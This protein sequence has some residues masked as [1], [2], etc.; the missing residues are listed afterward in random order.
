MFQKQ[1]TCRESWTGTRQLVHFSHK[2]DEETTTRVTV[3]DVQQACREITTK[4]KAPNGFVESEPLKHLR[5]MARGKP[6]TEPEGHEST[7][8]KSI[9][10]NA[11]SLKITEEGEPLRKIGRHWL[12]QSL[13]VGG[14]RQDDWKDAAQT[15]F[16]NIFHRQG[17]ASQ[18]WVFTKL[19]KRLTFMCKR[20]PITFFL[21]GR[22]GESGRHMG[23]RKSAGPDGVPYEGLRAILH[24]SDR[25]KHRLLEVFNDAL[26]RAHLPSVDESLTVLLAKCLLPHNWGQTRPITLFTLCS[27][28]LKTFSQLLLGGETSVDEPEGDPVSGEGETSPRTYLCAEETRTHVRRLGLDDL[29]P[30]I[31]LGQGL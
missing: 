24:H 14:R 1:T 9:G 21:G 19:A 23:K 26:Y 27:A 17:N 10:R 20:P 25:W 30:Q 3:E 28:I 29:C 8:G 18:T 13:F 15:H 5:R 12:V 2:L 6:L 11:S 4:Y 16:Q 7:S 31:G 22:S